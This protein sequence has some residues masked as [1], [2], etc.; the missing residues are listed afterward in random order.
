MLSTL[1]LDRDQSLA[2]IERI[3]LVIRVHFVY[4]V[5][6]SIAI[7]PVLTHSVMDRLGFSPGQGAKLQ[8]YSYTTSS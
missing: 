6:L 4:M 8:L 1:P 5:E 2:A 7:V 3:R